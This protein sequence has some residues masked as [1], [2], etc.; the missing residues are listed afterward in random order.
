MNK[1]LSVEEVKDKIYQV[2]GKKVMM[3]KDLAELYGVS[4][5]RL[6]EQVKRNSKRFPGDFMYL[7]TRQEVVNLR[8]QIATSSWG[9]RRYLIRVF[10][11][12]GVAMLSTVLNSERAIKVNIQ[13]MRAFVALRRWVITHEG[14]RRKVE[15]MEK[16][17]DGRFQIVFK[18]LK[19]L[20]EPPPKKPKGPIGFTANKAPQKH[21]AAFGR[22]G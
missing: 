18:A 22:L 6:N 17:Y 4:T 10:T 14:L 9:G 20:M 21:N 16:K 15:D 12:Q 1:V 13:I 5:K 8:S 7:L 19:E 11:E 2:R 3:D